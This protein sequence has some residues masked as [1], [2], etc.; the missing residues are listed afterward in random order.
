VRKS[1][2]NL[3]IKEHNPW[4]V[5]FWM[6]VIVVMGLVGVVAAFEM[7]YNQSD[8]DLSVAFK[9]LKG[10]REDLIKFRKE[11][12]RL[13]RENRSLKSVVAQLKSL[14]VID[15]H[16]HNRVKKRMDTMLRRNA[17]LQED[18]KFY[19]DLTSPHSR[20]RIIVHSLKIDDGGKQDD[21]FYFKLTL[22]QHQKK[23]RLRTTSG[24]VKMLIS[25]RRSDGRPAVLNLKDVMPAE[26]GNLT[27]NLVYLANLEGK[28]K[29]PAGF[30]PTQVRILV[31]P[32]GRGR[33]G[34]VEKRVQWPI[35][36]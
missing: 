1:K 29:L 9:D 24:S 10:T 35:N 32:K 30:Q 11:I 16:A 21:W 27:F 4:R 18:L 28:L 5:F 6:V 7:G 31:Y 23:D 36:T 22:I 26:E 3:V 19:R 12:R 13:R 2:S 20:F 15:S 25:G 17:K 8:D 33:R 34:R 14:N